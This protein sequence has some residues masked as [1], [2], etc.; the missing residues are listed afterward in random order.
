MLSPDLLIC[1]VCV[2]KSPYWE[3]G[4]VGDVLLT[5]EFYIASFQIR[6]LFEKGIFMLSSL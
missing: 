5:F 4:G 3:I 1:Y 2:A 6:G